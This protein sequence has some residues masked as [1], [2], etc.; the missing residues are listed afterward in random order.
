ME[1]GGLQKLT[2]LDYPGQVACTIFTAGCN[3]RCPFCHNAGLV[4]RPVEAGL[5]QEELLAFLKKR[6]GLLDGVCITGGEPLLH[7]D[8]PGLIQK[9]KDLGYRVKLDT[10]GTFPQ[11]LQQILQDGLCDYV[12]MDIKNAPRRYGETVG[13][14]A[15]AVLPAVQKS[16]ELLLGGQVD[17]E[18]R[19]TLVAQFHSIEEFYELG[20]WLQGARHYYLQR[21]VDS[22]DLIR[23]GLTHVPEDTAKAMVLAVQPYVPNT[24]LRGY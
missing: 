12:A 23:P 1:L 13:M 17:Y 19:T 22:G 7:P 21:F 8:L 24:A 9:I 15:G 18:F 5:Q 6:Q 20:P 14:D 10:N 11:K 4:T 2:L 16:V 3:L